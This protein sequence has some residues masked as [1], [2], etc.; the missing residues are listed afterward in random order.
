MTRQ[1]HTIPRRARR[2]LAVHHG[3]LLSALL[4][5]CGAYGSYP[6]TRT[7]GGQTRQGVFVSPPQYEDFVRGE[8]ALAAGDFRSAAE[9]Y[10][11]ARSGGDDDPLLCARL[12]DARD[13]LGDRAGAEHALADGEH[14]D[15][16]AEIVWLVRG[17]IAERHGELDAAIDAFERAHAA[18]PG[19][20]A[21]VLALAR[22]LEQSGH[23]DRA[24][25]SLAD[26]VAHAE[27]PLGAVRAS[28]ALALSRGD[29]VAIADAATRLARLA[30]GHEDEI[31]RAVRALRERGE[32]LVAGRLLAALPPES[33]DRELAIETAIAA[34]DRAAAERLLAFPEG[35]DARALVRDARHWLALGDAARAAELAEVAR[36]RDDAGSEATLVL[37]DARLAGGRPGDAA[38][39][40]ASI[41]AGAS[42][43]DA[44]REGLA[45]ALEAA[46]LPALGAEVAAAR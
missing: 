21:P 13:R 12:A 29:A 8:L 11:R 5:G 42:S 36:A 16:H 40:Y 27:T 14:L 37:A 18:E 20:E 24:A 10:E 41:P 44:A 32:V 7:V 3:L 28:L 23:D 9:S 17:E 2:A 26:Y 45:R 30:P 33:L 22:V 38:A 39:L 19:R 35:D 25:T 6:I 46:G 4:G 15:A 34:H 1:A 31:E 43:H